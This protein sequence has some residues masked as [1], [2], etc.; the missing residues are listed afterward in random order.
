[1]LNSKCKK[2]EGKREGN[3]DDRV[4]NLRQPLGYLILNTFQ[5]CK[6][7]SKQCCMELML[8]KPSTTKKM[9]L[10]PWRQDICPFYMT[11]Y[12]TVC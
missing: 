1:M 10:Q 7:C 9:G 5:V 11:C 8:A 12:Y 3:L 2:N 6:L 4:S